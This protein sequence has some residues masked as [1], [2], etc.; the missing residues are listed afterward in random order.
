MVLLGAVECSHV[1]RGRSGDAQGVSIAGGRLHFRSG[2]ASGDSKS[3]FY[4]TI[5]NV[6]LLQLLISAQRLCC[7][8]RGSIVVLLLAV[9]FSTGVPCNHG[10]Q[11]APA[12]SCP[13]ADILRDPGELCSKDTA[14]WSGR[15]S[16]DLPL[17]SRSGPWGYD[18]AD[19]SRLA[20]R[21]CLLY[22]APRPAV[23]RIFFNFVTFSQHESS[24]GNGFYINTYIY[25]YIFIY[26]CK[27]TQMT[28]FG[29]R[30]GAAKDLRDVG[31]PTL[32]ASGQATA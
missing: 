26:F 4:P 29:F 31:L 30:P 8:D 21:H 11:P 23:F 3:D 6:H 22:D 17:E 20:R 15:P 5:S 12:P 18:S 1:L 16:T 10:P 14:L 27:Q 13:A 19:L 7:R 32:R 2:P 24:G 28:V 25:I 9:L